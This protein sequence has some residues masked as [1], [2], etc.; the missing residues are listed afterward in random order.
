MGK[1]PIP[2]KTNVKR[3]AGKPD[4]NALKR[5]AQGG[6]ANT[7]YWLRRQDRPIKAYLVNPEKERRKLAKWILTWVVAIPLSFMAVMW[8]ILLIIDLF[9][10]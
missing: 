9:N 5:P 8:L 10:T 1:S 3:P 4:P 2:F 6:M 7:G